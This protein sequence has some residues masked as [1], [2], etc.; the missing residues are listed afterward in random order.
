[1]KI[2]N[3][4]E[5]DKEQIAATIDNEDFWYALTDGGYLKPEE[6]LLDKKDILEVNAAIIVLKEFQELCSQL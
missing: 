6:I 5:E 3:L 2:K 4:T 1:M